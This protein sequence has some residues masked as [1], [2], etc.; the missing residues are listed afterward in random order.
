MLARGQ[1]AIPAQRQAH[2]VVN[3]VA[4]V[5]DAVTFKLLCQRALSQFI[6]REIPVPKEEVV[7]SAH[8][9]PA[10]DEV[11]GG[12]PVDQELAVLAWIVSGDAIRDHAGVVIEEERVLHP[13]WLENGFGCELCK[14][15]LGC[16]LDHFGEQK[17]I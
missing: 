10:S 2:R 7:N 14:R 3:L 17:I 9:A 13:K 15:L 16:A 11:I 6:G 5:E 8:Q 1:A 4:V 12:G